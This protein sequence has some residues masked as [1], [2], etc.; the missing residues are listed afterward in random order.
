LQ[1]R[2]TKTD[3]HAGTVN[4]NCGG[5]EKTIDMKTLSIFNNSVT[6]GL[7]LGIVGGI[8]LVFAHNLRAFGFSTYVAE[9]IMLIAILTFLI[10]AALLVKID[11]KTN[12]YVKLFLSSFYTY[13]TMIMCIYVSL[14]IKFGVHQFQWRYALPVFGI[15]AIISLVTTFLITRGR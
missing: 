3:G 6:T 15:G 2:Q 14:F 12:K 10:T 13:V 1:S 9:I 4:T 5:T 11:G 7:S 8:I